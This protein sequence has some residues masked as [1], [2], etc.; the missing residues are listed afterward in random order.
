VDEAGLD[1]FSKSL[2]DMSRTLRRDMYGLGRPGITTDST[3]DSIRTPDTNPLS[4][5]EYSCVYWA[6][7]LLDARPSCDNAGGIVSTFLREKHLYWLE[8]L[9]VLRHVSEGVHV[10]VKLVDFAYH[11]YRFLV[12]YD[13]ECLET[14]TKPETAR[15]QRPRS[16]RAHRRRPQVHRDTCVND[17]VC[18]AP[19]ARV[20][21]AIH[22]NP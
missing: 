18:T 5:V 6:D 7:H 10:M 1:M 11:P 16:D 2:E 9:G 17:R 3:T 14:P 19:N 20:G 22:P 12:F 15:T 8:A 13:Y 21:T 4:S